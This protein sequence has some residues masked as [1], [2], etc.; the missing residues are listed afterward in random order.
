MG[1][2]DLRWFFKQLGDFHEYIK[3]NQ[4]LFDYIM[5]TDV[6]QNGMEY[7]VP[8]GFI[9]GSD[10]WTTPVKYSKDYYNAVSAP[11]KDFALIDGCGHSP[12]YDSPEEFCKELKGMLAEFLK[13]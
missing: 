5:V 10:D 13:K 6:R 7:K 1:L 2:D 12:H 4:Q 8:V 3:L 11:I 9:S